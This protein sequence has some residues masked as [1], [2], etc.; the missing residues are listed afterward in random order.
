[1]K[2]ELSVSCYWRLNEEQR[3]DL[4]DGEKESAVE[5]NTI[6]EL[7]DFIKKMGKNSYG[8]K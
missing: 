1:M 7:I 8:R 2:F 5:I 6:E 4:L 3:K